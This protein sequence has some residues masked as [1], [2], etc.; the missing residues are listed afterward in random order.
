M[1]I[2]FSRF[3][4]KAIQ[5]IMVAQ[6]EAKRFSHTYVGTEHILLGI[7]ADQDNIVVKALG[8]MDISV[9][10]IKKTV[11]ERLE[12]NSSGQVNLNIPFTQ[13]AKQ[14]LSNAWDEARKL[15]HNYVNVE[16]LFLSIFRSHQY[17]CQSIARNGS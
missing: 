13:Q 2:M 11:E 16:H 3:T 7:I 15:G 10:V 4:E 12:L 14:I 9:E 8:S 6:E 5:A 1:S 17:C